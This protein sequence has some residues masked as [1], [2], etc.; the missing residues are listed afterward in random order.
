MRASEQRATSTIR[1]ESPVTEKTPAPNGSYDSETSVPPVVI[2]GVPFTRVTIDEAVARIEKMVLSRRPHY[3]VTPNV[4]FLVQ[5]MKNVEL[6]RILL[7][8]PLVLCD[9][10]PVTWASRLLGN[11]LPERVPGADLAPRLIRLA[12]EKGY[13]LYFLGG[14]PAVTALAVRRL[15]ED[16]PGLNIVGHD[17]PPFRPLLEMDHEAVARRIRAARPDVLLVSFGCPKAEKW[18]AMH[19]RSLGVPVM[20]GVGATIDFLAQ[21]VKR[22]PRWMQRTGTEWIFR[23]LQEPRRLLGRYVTDLWFFAGAMAAQWWRMQVRW[24]PRGKDRNASFVAVNSVWQR[25]RLA[26]RL[27]ARSVRRGGELW[28]SIAN[29]RRDCL[30]EAAEVDFIDSTGVGALVWLQRRLRAAGQNLVIL[31]PSRAVQRALA[32]MRL[33]A[34]FQTAPDAVEARR[35]L[36]T[37]QTEQPPVVIN[38][39]SRPLAWRGEITAAN[40]EEVWALSGPRLFAPGS[41]EKNLVIDLTDVRFI[42]SAGVNLMLRAR[43]QA[44]QQGTRLHFAGAQPDVRKALR[45]AKFELAP[46]EDLA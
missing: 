9:G 27:D 33:E 35:V 32:L 10:T 11:P 4:D 19:Y 25:V 15:R 3:V 29:H 46:P 1:P 24:P 30:L 31:A 6:H 7:E 16:Y 17:S 38:G 2:L 14:A 34:A 5:A 26:G 41:R 21:R 37:R 40:A 22:A 44:R 45:S 36:E 43:T 18:M 42:D 39:E 28:E 8:A 12:A 23:L 20:I 13:R